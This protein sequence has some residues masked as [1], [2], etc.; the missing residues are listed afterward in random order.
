MADFNKP[1]CPKCGSKMT[2]LFT[3]AVCDI[4]DPPK[5]APKKVPVFDPGTF[6]ITYHTITPKN[7]VLSATLPPS[8]A[9]IY[10]P[11]PMGPAV[12]QTPK[13]PFVPAR[14]SSMLWD[15][16]ITKHDYRDI[17]PSISHSERQ[18]WNSAEVVWAFD[19]TDPHR[20][21]H[22]IKNRWVKTGAS[23]KVLGNDWTILNM[24]GWRPQGATARIAPGEH[25]VC[26]IAVP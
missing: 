19:P 24:I 21:A 11:N 22:N 13:P 12:P 18:I 17:K 26:L 2:L 14:L 15:P 3:S 10:L 9:P 4:C 8:T 16:L 6:E 7:R 5:N 1:L 25:V 20:V 23:H